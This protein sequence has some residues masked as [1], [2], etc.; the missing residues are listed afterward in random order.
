MIAFKAA[1]I[2]VNAGD[3]MDANIHAACELV[4][5][6]RAA[7]AELAL[8]PENVAMMTWGRDNIIARAMPEEG[9]KALA[10]FRSLARDTGI[11]LHCG[12]LAVLIGDGRVANRS[13]LLDPE[14][15]VVASYDKIHMFDV[16]LGGGET[17][18]ESATF[19]PGEAAVVAGTPWGRLGLS[20]CYDLRF[21][22]LY[23][24]LAKAGADFLAV[25]AAFTR[26]TGRAHWHVLMRARA[27]ETGCYI[28]APAQC[29]EHPNNRQTFGHSL[30][31]S[32]WGTV[33]GDAGEA[34]GFVVARI[35]PYEVVEARR[36][37]PALTHDRS[38]RRPD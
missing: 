30:I 36:K 37:I 6:A 27:I 24:D 23:R 22:H 25:P 3:D 8:L 14:G 28:L 4:C 35:D 32:P 21:P 2:Q 7:G 31:V 18:C 34:P 26:T 38:Y 29:G 15:R 9:H 5:Q 20:I 10:A 17:Y 1:C 16:D 12:S 13:F 33:L 11:W 19:Q